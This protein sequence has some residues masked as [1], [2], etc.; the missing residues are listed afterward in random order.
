LTPRP[1]TPYCE[2]NAWQWTWFA[3]HDPA[4]L[5]K[6]FDGPENFT[7]KLDKLFD[8][9]SDLS[10][11][12]VSPDISGM[13]GQYA[14][15][16][17]PSHHT[18]YMYVWAG[19]PWKTQRRV[20]QIMEELYHTGPKGLCGNDDCGQMSAWYIFSALGFYPV[21]SA[22]GIYVLGS[23]RVKSAKISLPDGKAFEVAAKGQSKKNVYVQSVS[24]NGKPLNRA[25]VT[26]DEITNGGKLVFKMGPAPN[27]G[28]KNMEIPPRF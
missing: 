23:P 24:L 25:F 17:E 27:E 8:M 20:R 11:E 12:H 1:Q 10:G 16:N 28:L 15:G 21:D 4:E 19:Q 2:G 13:I 7:D 14:Q 9:P 5:V 22:N 6:L 3:P 26:H 18:A